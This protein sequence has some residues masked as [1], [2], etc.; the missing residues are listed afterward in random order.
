MTAAVEGALKGQ[1]LLWGAPTYD[2]C[3]VGWEEMREAAGGIATFNISR[4]EARFPSGGM[5][6]FRS[7][8]DPDNARGHTADG[9]LLDEAGFIIERAWT[10]VLRP[11]ISD[12]GGW[13]L[14]GGTPSGRNW[15]WRE[16]E[17]A[18]GRP[19]AVAWQVPTLGVEIV[20][21]QLLRKVH[22]LENPDFH[23][24]EAQHL[25]NTLPAR[26]FE[27]EF[28]AAFVDDAGGV[29]RGVAE[30]ATAVALGGAQEGRSYV[31]GVDWGKHSDFTVL[32][33]LDVQARA[34]AAMERFNQIDYQVQLGRLKALYERFRPYSVIPE[35][36]SM[37]EPLIEQLFRDGL[38]VVPFAT[39]GPSKMRIIDALTLAFERKRIRILN[40]PILISELQAY[41]MTRLP[42][43]AM[44]YSAPEGMHDDCV[45]SLA[46]AWSALGGEVGVDFADRV[47]DPRDEI[48]EWCS[49]DN[50]AIWSVG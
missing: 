9:I 11:M 15:F 2:Q 25:F 29:F 44:R 3:R 42:S 27:Q 1:S 8:D 35:S 18:T 5:V 12:T 50:D 33:V 28:L 17:A 46:L 30:A 19:D 43:G 45:I 47:A 37:G 7:M 13:V 14:A 21:G 40:D 4:M 38:P 22:P 10:E 49:A 24:A 26:V 34:Q 41:E 48:D 16:H 6:T 32:T 31:M 23:F 39:T 36:N 20:D